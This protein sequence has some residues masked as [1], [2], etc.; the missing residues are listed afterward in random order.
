MTLPLVE[1]L[2]P[3]GSVFPASTCGRVQLRDVDDELGG[4]LVG[5]AGDVQL[6]SDEV[7]QAAVDLDAHRRALQLDVDGHLDGLG[8]QHALEVDV[9][10]AARD[11]VHLHLADHGVAALVGAGELKQEDRVRGQREVEQVRRSSGTGTVLKQP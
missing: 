8:H 2:D 4:D 9:Q 6:A 5:G 1:Q 7:E 11:R 10:D 3:S